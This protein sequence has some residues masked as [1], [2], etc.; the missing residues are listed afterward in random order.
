MVKYGE[1]QESLLTTSC[2]MYG[3][4]SEGIFLKIISPKHSN[5]CFNHF[6]EKKLWFILD[7]DVTC[8]L[9]YICYIS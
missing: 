1:M 8:A 9:D 5:I 4:V 7:K 3:D 2:K 6:L